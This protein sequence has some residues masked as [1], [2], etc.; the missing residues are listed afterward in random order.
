MVAG[1]PEVKE[2]GGWWRDKE[3]VGVL[4]IMEDG[5]QRKCVQW[6]NYG[7]KLVTQLGVNG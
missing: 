5:R 4:T 1:I 6:V 7:Q 3:E 2:E